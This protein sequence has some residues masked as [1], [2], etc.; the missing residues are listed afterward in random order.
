M[1]PFEELLDRPLCEILPMMQDAIV[2]RT[3]YRG[4]PAL[5]CPTDAWVYL[6]LLH[7]LRPKVLIEIGTRFGGSTLFLA[8][9][10]STLGEGRLIG[11]DWTTRT[12][13]RSSR[14]T[15]ESS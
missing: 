14:A 4:V 2:S 15:R 13:P 8:D 9:A 11:L 7:E 12:C 10:M 5:K 3:T 6:E 1:S